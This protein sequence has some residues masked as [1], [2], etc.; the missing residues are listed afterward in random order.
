[1]SELQKNKKASRGI[2]SR[3]KPKKNQDKTKCPLTAK[4]EYHRFSVSVPK[5]L[6]ALVAAAAV[7]NNQRVNAFIVNALQAELKIPKVVA[8]PPSPKLNSLKVFMESMSKFDWTAALN[9]E[10]QEKKSHGNKE[11]D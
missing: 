9:E 1:M 8:S 6:Y 2:V 11:N 3:R 10:E 4:S 5:D 7:S